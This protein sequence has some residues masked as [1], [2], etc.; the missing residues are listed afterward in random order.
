MIRPLI[1]I[2]LTL[3][4]AGAFA[5]TGL[6]ATP[7]PDLMSAGHGSGT[8]S[9]VTVTNYGP[10]Y[11]ELTD[12]FAFTSG[13]RTPGAMIRITNDTCSGARLS[14][15]QGQCKVTFMFDDSCPQKGSIQYTLTL[16][17]STGQALQ[18]P[19]WG[20]STGGVCY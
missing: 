13:Q 18:V 12:T 7:D 15:A 6:V 16:N 1:A 17:S 19:V 9:V 20:N 8:S 2:A 3:A 10:D 14:P 4:A 11:A 5:A